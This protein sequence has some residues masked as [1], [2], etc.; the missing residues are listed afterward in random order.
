MRHFSRVSRF[1][2]KM[3]QVGQSLD[4]LAD[5][6]ED[7]GRGEFNYACAY[8]L[9][10]Q[11]KKMPLRKHALEAI[12][13]AMLAGD[14]IPRFF[15]QLRVHLHRAALA[16]Q[17]LEMDAATEYL[18]RYETSLTAMEDDLH[19]QRVKLVFGDLARSSQ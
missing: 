13:R 11:Q 16:I 9:Q 6:E 14:V 8:I 15:Q 10:S 12:S 7:L 5:I 19:R 1:A 3:A 18:Q 17:P 4:D 2:D